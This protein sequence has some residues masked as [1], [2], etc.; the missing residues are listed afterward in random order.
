MSQDQVRVLRIIEY[1]GSREEV[2]K[3]LKHSSVPNNGSKIV[4]GLEIRSAIVGDF[5]EILKRFGKD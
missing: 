4:G 1:V 3:T 2:E 5:P